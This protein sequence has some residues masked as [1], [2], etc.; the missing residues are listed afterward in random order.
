[1][2]RWPWVSKST[3]DRHTQVLVDSQALLS[4]QNEWLRERHE[5]LLDQI[6]SLKK[7]GFGRPE[8]ITVPEP[9][10]PPEILMRAIREVSPRQDHA[11][12]MNFRWAMD[13]QADWNDPAKMRE[14]AA[15]IRR[16]AA[17]QDTVDDL[18]DNS[19]EDNE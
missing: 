12:A 11:Y 1:M 7:E 13:R 10:M 8:A 19:D 17:P 3:Y 4:T 14:Y 9:M 5:I 18:D 6:L 15:L 2:L 16:G